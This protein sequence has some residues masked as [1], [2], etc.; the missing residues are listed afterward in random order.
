MVGREAPVPKVTD[1]CVS[2]GVHKGLVEE[3]ERE[4]EGGRCTSFLG[5]EDGAIVFALSSIE[6]LSKLV[7]E[8]SICQ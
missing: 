7:K 4:R 5:Q 2:F 3:K 8:L 6:E 1:E